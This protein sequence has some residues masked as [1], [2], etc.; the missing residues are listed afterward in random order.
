MVQYVQSRG[1]AH[2]R[3]RAAGE[4]PSE[5]MGEVLGVLKRAFVVD[6]RHAFSFFFFA[7]VYFCMFARFS[8]DFATFCSMFHDFHVF[9][10][11]LK[12]LVPEV[13]PPSWSTC[14]LRRGPF[15]SARSIAFPR[16]PRRHCLG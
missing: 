15:F 9:S 5:V 7:Y 6:L 8:H 4:E 16:C 14:H 11:G 10:C 1:S 12:R 2:V 13:C 3:Q